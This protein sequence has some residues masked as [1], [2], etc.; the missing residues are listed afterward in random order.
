L[1][2]SLFRS[3]RTYCRRWR[4]SVQPSSTY[5]RSLPDNEH[6]YQLSLPPT[7]HYRF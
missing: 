5:S 3:D 7:T 6:I 4:A 1:T 2:S